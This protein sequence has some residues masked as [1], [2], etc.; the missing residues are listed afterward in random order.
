MK[1]PRQRQPFRTPTMITRLGRVMDGLQRMIT[2]AV[3]ECP[4]CSGHF[5]CS[6]TIIKIGHKKACSRNCAR[7]VAPN[8]AKTKTYAPVDYER[9]ATHFAVEIADYSRI[10]LIDLW[11]A[12]TDYELPRT[13]LRDKN[14]ARLNYEV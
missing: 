7:L 14:L 6:E 1:I 10:A 12:H 2:T 13:D 5:I 9:I 8:P 3:Y 4:V 11:N